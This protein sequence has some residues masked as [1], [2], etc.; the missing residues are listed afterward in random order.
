MRATWI[1][2]IAAAITAL[3]LASLV[4]WTVPKAD[5]RATYVAA[6]VGFTGV[7]VTL[8]LQSL[9]QEYSEQRKRRQL[10]ESIHSI[11]LGNCRQLE[12][13]LPRWKTDLENGKAIS[14]PR[15]QTQFA[16]NAI[17]QHVSELT[18]DAPSSDY[19]ALAHFVESIGFMIQS[20]PDLLLENSVK[21]RDSFFI[22]E[23]SAAAQANRVFDHIVDMARQLRV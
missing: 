15:G 11:I 1:L 16:L 22:I 7:I 12:Q 8:F 18:G 20:S 14:I 9:I 13:V 23:P 5:V 17:Q 10:R 19:V 4:F 2:I 3:V 21:V 6:I